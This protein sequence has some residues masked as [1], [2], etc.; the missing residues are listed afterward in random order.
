MGAARQ[1]E[2]GSLRSRSAGPNTPKSEV[3]RE[4]G[5]RSLQGILQG[6]TTPASG[7]AL[8]PPFPSS[9]PHCPPPQSLSVGNVTTLLG[10]NVGDL[11]KARSHPIISSWLRS[12]NRSA[13]SELGLDT[14]P[15]G[16]TS[17]AHPTTGT[18]STTLWTRHQAPTSEGPGSTAPSS[19]TLHPPSSP[20]PDTTP[21]FSC[22]PSHSLLAT[23]PICLLGQHM[24]DTDLALHCL[25]S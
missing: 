18:P 17:S 6:L 14:D 21:G 7:Q 12:L 23:L 9:T 11:H 16:P 20:D 8:T 5:L 13:L 22:A 3:C 1:G 10:P 2:S 25:L 15:T 4:W 24:G 19:G